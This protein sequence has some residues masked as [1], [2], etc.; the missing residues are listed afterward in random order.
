MCGYK[1]AAPLELW[2]PGGIWNPLFFCCVSSADYK[3][4]RLLRLFAA[5]LL[6]PQSLLNPFFI[7]GIREIRGFSVAYSL[8]ITNVLRLLRLFAAILLCFI[9]VALALNLCV[10]HPFPAFPEVKWSFRPA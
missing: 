9:L 3:V 4:L 6:P 10:R 5:I 2:E 1:H 7:R 8:P